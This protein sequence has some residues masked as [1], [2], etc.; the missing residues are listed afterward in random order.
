MPQITI[1]QLV[2][3]NI[4]EYAKYSVA[5]VKKYA[6]AHGYHYHIQRSKTVKDMHIN[7]TKIDFL[8]NEL[9][10]ASKGDDSFVVL[11]DADTVIVKP[12]RTIE[13]FIEKYQK[14]DTNILMANDTPFQITGKKKPNAGFVIVRNNEMGR[15]IIAKWIDASRNEGARY[16]DIHPR[17]QLV[18]WNCV[19]PLYKKHQVVLPKY[20]FHKPIWLIP[21]PA[22][23]KRYLYH[24]TS[25]GGK[26]RTSMMETYYNKTYQDASNLQSVEKFLEENQNGVVSPIG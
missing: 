16:N 17:N 24:V 26:S 6:I 19:E 11:L 12:E 1:I 7:W 20:Y 18:Y 13:F 10:A 25:T 9:N 14:T 3:P 4:D 8:K 21:K 22:N 5:S 23:Q 2:T 15:E